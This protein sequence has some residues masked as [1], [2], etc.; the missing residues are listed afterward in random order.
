MYL[1]TPLLLFVSMSGIPM[2]CSLLEMWMIFLWRALAH[3]LN[4]TG[5]FRSVSMLG[6]HKLSIKELFDYAC[7]N[8]VQGIRWLVE[9]GLALRPLQQSIKNWFQRDKPLF[10]LFKREGSSSL[11]GEKVIPSR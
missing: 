3:R 10:G 11:I 6:L 5:P 2:L 7:G 9:Q 1:T 8:G 4:T